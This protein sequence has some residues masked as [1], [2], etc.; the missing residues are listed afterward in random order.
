MPRPRLSLG[1]PALREF[2]LGL[3]ALIP[4]HSLG[5]M[6][7]MSSAQQ[8]QVVGRAPATFREW[9]DVVQLES[10]GR[11]AAMPA[12]AHEC[13]AAAVA[14]PDAVAQGLGDGAARSAPSTCAGA[15]EPVEELACTGAATRFTRKRRFSKCATKCFIARA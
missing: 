2:A 15:S 13:A 9:R 5:L 1:A 4:E 10:P 11:F 3:H 12:R 6:L 8:A 14:L 7:V